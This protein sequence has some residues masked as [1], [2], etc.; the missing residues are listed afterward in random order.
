MTVNAYYGGTLKIMSVTELTF[1]IK[2][3]LETQLRAVSVRGEISNLKIQSSGHF[4]FS[5]KDA[6]AQISAVLFKGNASQLGR[7]PKDGDQ[8]IAIGELSVYAPRGNY[9]LIARELQ[10]LGVGE[11]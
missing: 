7:V 8:I 6:G 11:L 10:F 5:I 9:Q 4:Y 3:L 1:V 2:S